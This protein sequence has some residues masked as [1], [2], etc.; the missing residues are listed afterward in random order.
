[1]AWEWSHTEEGYSNVY[2][3]IHDLPLED[4][5]VILA[6]WYVALEC[7]DDDDNAFLDGRY[8]NKLAEFKSDAEKY[9]FDDVYAQEIWDLCSNDHNPGGHTWYGRT[10]DSGGFSAWVCPYGC[11][12]VSFDRNEDKE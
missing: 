9:D 5:C 10:C 2:E 1:M 8:D 6:E 11:H 3:N 4:K 7:Y 12:L